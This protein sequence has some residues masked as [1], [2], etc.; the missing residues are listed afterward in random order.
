MCL[1]AADK[2]RYYSKREEILAKQKEYLNRKVSEDPEGFRA[3]RNEISAR[4]RANPKNTIRLRFMKA[5]YGITP[6]EY[7]D[8]EEAQ[9]GVCKICGEPP[10]KTRLH[11]DHC[12]KTGKVRGLLC[13]KHNLLLGYCD[14]SVE[15]LNKAAAYLAASQA[16]EDDYSI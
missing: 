14:D 12:H 8:M 3:N 1:T 13:F 10:D 5:R 4:H 7:L 11:V 15:V 2:A 9:G 6:E 16:A